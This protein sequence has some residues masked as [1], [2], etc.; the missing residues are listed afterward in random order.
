MTCDHCARAVQ[1]GIGKLPGGTGVDVARET[2][3]VTGDPLPGQARAGG[4]HD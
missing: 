2:V 1:A 4:L 3:R